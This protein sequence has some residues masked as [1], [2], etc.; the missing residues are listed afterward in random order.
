M[1]ML[2]NENGRNVDKRHKEQFHKWFEKK[3]K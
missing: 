2:R 3:V 1:T